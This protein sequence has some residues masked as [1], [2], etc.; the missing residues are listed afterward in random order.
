MYGPFSLV[1]VC[2]VGYKLIVVDCE[3]LGYPAPRFLLA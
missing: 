2:G 3:P 1:V